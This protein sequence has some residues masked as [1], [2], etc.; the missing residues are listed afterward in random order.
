MII[1]TDPVIRRIIDA[2]VRQDCLFHYRLLM[3]QQ[4]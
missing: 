4:R 2:N 1:R 3:S